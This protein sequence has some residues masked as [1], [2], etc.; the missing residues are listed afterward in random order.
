MGSEEEEVN[1]TVPRNSGLRMLLFAPEVLFPLA[2]SSR[3][4]NSLGGQ[5]CVSSSS[6]PHT[7]TSSLSPHENPRRQALF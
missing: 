7:Y 6:L 2:H 5:L 1:G 3:R 4:G